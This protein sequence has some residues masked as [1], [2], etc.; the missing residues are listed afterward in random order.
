MK[1]APISGY[2]DTKYMTVLGIEQILHNF[3]DRTFANLLNLGQV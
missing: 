2:F 1:D 3:K